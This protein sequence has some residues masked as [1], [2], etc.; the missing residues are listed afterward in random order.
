M[1]VK[2]STVNGNSRSF[3]VYQDRNKYYEVKYLLLSTYLVSYYKK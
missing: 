1:P 3:D 2:K